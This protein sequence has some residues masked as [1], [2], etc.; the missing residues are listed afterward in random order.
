MYCNSSVKHICWCR[1]TY[2]VCPNRLLRARYIKYCQL[3]NIIYTA[4]NN[5]YQI[6]R[7]SQVSCLAIAGNNIQIPHYNNYATLLI[8]WTVT[9]TSISDSLNFVNIEVV[10]DIVKD[11]VEF[12]EQSDYLHWCTRTGQLRE[13]NYVTAFGQASKWS[14]RGSQYNAGACMGS[15]ERQN[16]AHLKTLTFKP[17]F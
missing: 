3:F 6:E 12:V 7:C 5:L 8:S 10:E 14:G 2:D 13:P 1:C 17:R 11:S 4:F 15:H 9:L 16:N